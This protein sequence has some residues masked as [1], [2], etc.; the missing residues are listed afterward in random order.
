MSDVDGLVEFLK[1]QL[2]TEHD[3]QAARQF[4]HRA[5]HGVLPHLIATI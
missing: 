5:L 3:L 4:K 2:F 1:D